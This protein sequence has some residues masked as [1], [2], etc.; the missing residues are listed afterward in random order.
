MEPHLLFRRA[1]FST[2]IL[3]VLCIPPSSSA[4]FVWRGWCDTNDW[5][6]CLRVLPA[7]LECIHYASNWATYP[8]ELGCPPYPNAASSVDLGDNHVSLANGATMRSL[9]MTGRL[10]LSSAT[11]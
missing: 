8:C 4:Q 6:C 10:D 5:Y 9:E 7:P 11:L 1:S 3:L 2:T